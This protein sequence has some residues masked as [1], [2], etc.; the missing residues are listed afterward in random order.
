[1]KVEDVKITGDDHVV[2]GLFSRPESAFAT[3]VLAHGAGAGMRHEFMERFTELFFERDI[4]VLRYQF[5][6]MEAGSRRPD[7][8]PTCIATVR[9]AFESAREIAGD[10]PIFLAGKSMGGRMSSMAMAEEHDERASGIIFLGFPL[11]PAGKEG[12]KR[13]DHLSDVQVPMYFVQGTRDKL[14][15]MELIQQTVTPLALADMFV[16]EGADHGFKVLKRSG[17]IQAAVEVEMADAVANW[18]RKRV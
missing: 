9:A 3:L 1:M 18:L 10:L 6:Y 17:L 13:G 11:H 8:A 16:V 15:D 4:A 5:P 12:T 2:S 14:A 7:R